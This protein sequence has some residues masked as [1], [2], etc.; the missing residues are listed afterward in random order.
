MAD[1]E[2]ETWEDWEEGE[3]ECVSL[4]AQ[5]VCPSGQAALARDKADYGFDLAALKVKLGLDLYGMIKVL[6][7][8]QGHAQLRN[9]HTYRHSASA[10]FDHVCI[11]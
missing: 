7:R 3:D 10:I 1:A 11:L 8:L 6:R 2:D 9:M 4:F 5:A